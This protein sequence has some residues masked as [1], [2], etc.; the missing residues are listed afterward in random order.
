MLFIKLIAYLPFWFWY[1]IADALYVLAFYVIGYRKKVVLENLRLSFPEKTEAE[2]KIIAKGFYRN[3][4]DIVVEMI[5]MF[6][7]SAEELSRRV[8]TENEQIMKPLVEKHGVVLLM[9][10]HQCNWEWLG[11][12]VHIKIG[13]VDAIYH[14]L[15]NK[16]V[17]ALMYRLRSQYGILPVSM[18]QTIREVIK[19]KN[20]K[21]MIGVIADQVPPLI[22]AAHWTMFMNQNTP[23]FT[24]AEKIS[25][26]YQYPQVYINVKR[27]KRG[28]YWLRFELMF[29]PPFEGVEPQAMIHNY[30]QRLERT[31]RENPSDW[32]WSHKRWKHQPPKPNGKLDD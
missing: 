7:M 25:R 15:H 10:S 3:L 24:G 4:A 1:R 20:I 11:Q 27:L 2:I 16:K 12:S 13:Q 5:K 14:P 17:D 32:L 22:E 8:H 30:A 31:I 19:R 6:D 21:R 23:F 9:A 28:H 26:T 29:E 18:Q